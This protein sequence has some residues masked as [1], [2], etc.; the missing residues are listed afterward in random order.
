M[1]NNVTKGLNELLDVATDLVENV[2]YDIDQPLPPEN[3]TPKEDH[4]FARENLYKL[5]NK[6]SVALDNLIALAAASDSPNAYGSVSQLIKTL[7]DAN[8]NLLELHVTRKELEQE[9]NK[10]PAQHINAEKAVFVGSTAELQKLMSESNDEDDVDE[11][12]YDGE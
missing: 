4:D 7:A 8:E 11:D 3:N 6:G 12:E 5:I 9:F 2:E 1:E 10:P